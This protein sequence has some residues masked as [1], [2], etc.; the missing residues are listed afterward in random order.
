MTEAEWLTCTEPVKMLKATKSRL[1]HRKLRLFAVACS[2]RIQGSLLDPRSRAAI[3]VAERFAD[4]EAHE[5]ELITA[6]QGAAA[7]HKEVFDAKGK[8]VA[9]LEW[10]AEYT[11]APFAYH[12]AENVSWMSATAGEVGQ[13]T[14]ANYATQAAIVRDVFGNPFHPFALDPQWL[15]PAV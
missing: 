4:G 2:R 5:T 6:R 1:K 9:C 3:D 12:A 14:S 13:V 8:R 10:A 7:A 11:A 15:T